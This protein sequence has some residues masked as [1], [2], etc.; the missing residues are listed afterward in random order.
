MDLDRFINNFDL[1]VSFKEKQY[2][3]KLNERNE[4][5]L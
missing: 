1:F 2:G 3:N 5:N 4:E